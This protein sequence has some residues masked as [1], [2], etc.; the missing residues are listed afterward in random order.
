MC[1]EADA[2]DVC[3]YQ[4]R[5]APDLASVWSEC[6]FEG[7]RGWPALVRCPPL[8]SCSHL[9]IVCLSFTNKSHEQSTEMGAAAEGYDY[10]LGTSQNGHDVIADRKWTLPPVK[11]VD[12][13]Q[14]LQ[15]SIWCRHM[16]IVFGGLG[17]LEEVVE[18]DHSLPVEPDQV[19]FKSWVLE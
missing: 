6:P 14:F 4:V 8:C 5:V 17:G 7:D 16:M 11:Y 18:T 2:A 10:S 9:I 12:E 13:D 19:F 1:S 15:L 3:S